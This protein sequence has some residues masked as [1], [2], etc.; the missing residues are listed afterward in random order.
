MSNHT[1]PIQIIIGSVLGAT[2]YVAEAISDACNKQNIQTR[3]HFTPTLS[4]ISTDAPWIVCTSTHGAGELP[5]NIQGFHRSLSDTQLS[6]Q[7]LVVGLGDSSYDTYCQG[8]AIISSALTV[9]G[10][11]LQHEPFLVDVLHHP[12]PEDVVVEWITPLL[13]KLIQHSDH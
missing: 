4:D 10:V 2:E 12:I 11:T 5:D 1:Q 13:S 6:N 7:A 3:L 9:A 8:A